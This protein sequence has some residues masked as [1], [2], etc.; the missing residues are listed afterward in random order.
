[1]T[2]SRNGLIYILLQ[3]TPKGASMSIYYRIKGNDQYYLATS[4]VDMLTVYL[5]FGTS[6]IKIMA[7]GG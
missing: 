7:Y 4:D 3:A 6:N 1:M 5:R 2:A